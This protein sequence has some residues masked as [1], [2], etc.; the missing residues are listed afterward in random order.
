MRRNL[1]KKTLVNRTEIRHYCSAKF[2]KGMADSFIERHL[3]EYIEIA[4]TLQEEPRLEAPHVFPNVTIETMMESVRFHLSDL[5]FDL[6]EIAISE[7]EDRSPTRV[8]ISGGWQWEP[9]LSDLLSLT[10]NAIILKEPRDSSGATRYR[11]IGVL[12]SKKLP[13]RVVRESQSLRPSF[14]MKSMLSSLTAWQPICELITPFS[15]H[16][17]E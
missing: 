11:T 5:I 8:V 10:F 3:T 2:R 1:E 9:C 15:V 4:T 16:F 14:K 12:L 7:W 6:D 17:I 13:R